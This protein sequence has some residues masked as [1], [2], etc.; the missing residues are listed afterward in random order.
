[1]DWR[2]QLAKPTGFTGRIVGHLMAM[3]NRQRSDWVFL[4]LD[5]KSGDR[6]LEIGFGSGADIARES[7]LRVHASQ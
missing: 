7:A 5:L 3:K 1:M 4:L 6:V 2:N